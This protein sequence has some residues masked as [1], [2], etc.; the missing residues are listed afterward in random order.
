MTDLRGGISGGLVILTKYK[1]DIV[2]G[3]FDP[4]PAAFMPLRADPDDPCAPGY[5]ATPAVL[6]MR[7][8]HEG[9]TG[10]DPRFVSVDRG[11][12]FLLQLHLAGT[13]FG[14]FLMFDGDTD[15][16]ASNAQG[17]WARVTIPS[18][19]DGWYRVSQGGG[20]R[21]WDTVETAHALWQ[22]L[23]APPIE[24]FGLSA[25]VDA[26]RQYVWLD[27]PNSDYCWPLPL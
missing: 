17:A 11:F 19:E 2:E 14:G 9:T 21:P 4:Y 16:L 7:N 8:G 3:R 23:G 5:S 12:R 13:R 24:R 22:R 18:G 15:M 26:H 25:S 10:V 27:D 6:D 20:L 1:N